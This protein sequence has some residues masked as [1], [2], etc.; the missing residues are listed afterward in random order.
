MGWLGDGN[1]N[2]PPPKDMNYAIVDEGVKDV[3][4][5]EQTPALIL[6]VGRAGR[7][8]SNY[9][10]LMLVFPAFAHFAWMGRGGPSAT[11]CLERKELVDICKM[12]WGFASLFHQLSVGGHSF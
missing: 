4:K 5:E 3:A 11:Q 8:I 9:S 7:F 12:I 6:D 10:F 2:G 1:L